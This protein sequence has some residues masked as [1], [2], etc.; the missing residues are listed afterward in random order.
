MH[1]FKPGPI[2]QCI[3]VSREVHDFLTRFWLAAPIDH[4]QHLGT[5]VLRSWIGQQER[6]RLL[7]PL[8]P[9]PTEHCYL[10]AST[11][12]RW[13]DEAGQ[14]T[15]VSVARPCRAGGAFVFSGRGVIDANG[16][17]RV[18]PGRGPPAGP[19]QELGEAS[20]GSAASLRT[21]LR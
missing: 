10:T 15:Q 2:V 16:K 9:A 6:R 13:L 7:R 20:S 17:K 5:G 1:D 12:Q 21:R 18:D 11:M 3:T 14:V 4:W 19:I 8:D